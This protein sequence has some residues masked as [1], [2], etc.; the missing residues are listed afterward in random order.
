MWLRDFLAADVPTVRII[1]FGY[2]ARLDK[3]TTIS[4]LIDYRRSFLGQLLVS[5]KGIEV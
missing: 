2:E 1:I 3:T 4:R 5:R